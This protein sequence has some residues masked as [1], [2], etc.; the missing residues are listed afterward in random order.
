MT[1]RCF[2]Y[3]FLLF[4]AVS[5]TSGEELSLQ[6]LNPM[7][8]PR[9]DAAILLTRGEISDRMDIPEGKLPVLLNEKREP[10]PCQA[11]DVDR[12]GAWDELF[13]L[14][15]MPGRG[16]K[17]LK[18]KFVNPEE[19]PV[20]EARTNVRLG[21][22]QRPGYP[23]LKTAER[24]EGITYDNHER[25]AEV[26]QMEG[27][28]WENDMVGFRNY[29]DQRNGMDIFGKLTAKMVLDSVG[30]AG[31]PSYHEPGGWGM[32]ILKVNT[33]LGAGAIGYLYNDSMYRVGDNG[34]G[35]YELVFEGSQRSRFN[36]TYSNW[37]VDG[38]NL[39]VIHQIEIAGGRHYYQGVVTYSGTDKELD[40]VTG[41]VNMKSDQLHVVEADENHTALITH[42]R[43]SE[44][45]TNLAMALLVPTE[46]LVSTGEAPESG[47]GITQTYY[48]ILD[49]ISG[50]PVT[51]RFYALW[52]R[53]D[54]RWAS[55]DEV[56]GYLR[57]EAEKWT[58]SLVYPEIR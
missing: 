29:L 55:L 40:L 15:D 54:P 43:Q 19:Y 13:G 48:A 8:Q 37:K 46:Y 9:N 56:T 32:D 52:E 35:K 36:L 1:Q 3:T 51:Y 50:V 21:D 34:S 49:A 11:D 12:D 33:S 7:D 57:S 45:S 2:F 20:F 23:E 24:L 31:A 58:R 53:E 25:T 18:L 5:C 38:L 30:V 4:L 47:E 27:P 41:I 44:D 16:Q 17:E 42:D 39:E 6:V 28:A 26:Y 22:A 10:V 14:I